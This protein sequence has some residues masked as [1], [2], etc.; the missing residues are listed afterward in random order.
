MECSK[1]LLL[2]K[3]NDGTYRPF[4]VVAREEEFVWSEDVLNKD[5]IKFLPADGSYKIIHPGSTY[6][7]TTEDWL[8]NVHSDGTVDLD[9]ALSVPEK[10]EQSETLRLLTTEITLPFNVDREQFFCN[11]TAE[12]LLE[13]IYSANLGFN[14]ISSEDGEINKVVFYIANPI[15]WFHPEFK[16]RTEY[17]NAKIHVCITAKLKLNATEEGE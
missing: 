6:R 3:Q 16:T 17:S 14:P 5:L 13:E 12:S 4:F 1:G 10:F 15:H 9:A 7:F 11:L 8:V 2:E